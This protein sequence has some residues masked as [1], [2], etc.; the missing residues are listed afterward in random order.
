M[1]V[2]WD[3]SD[4]DGGQGI[5]AGA[6]VGYSFGAQNPNSPLSGLRMELE[7]FYRQSKHDQNAALLTRVI[8][9]GA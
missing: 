8:R 7:Y 6:A 5:L 2:D 9:S 4:F 1:S 3:W